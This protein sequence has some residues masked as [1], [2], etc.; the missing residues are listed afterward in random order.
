[1]SIQRYN[2][3]PDHFEDDTGDWVGYEDHIASNAHYQQAAT[4]NWQNCEIAADQRDRV[5]EYR[6]VALELLREIIQ[7]GQAYRECT[8][9]SS[10]TGLR[11]HA[12]LHPNGAAA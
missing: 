6:K 3:G 2:A 11:I 9:H 10:P 12:V 1:M 7:G 5:N 4:A 8:D